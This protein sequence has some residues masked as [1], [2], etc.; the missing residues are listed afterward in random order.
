MAR[1]PQEITRD[2]V[3]YMDAPLREATAML[4]EPV[5]TIVGYYF[6]WVEADG[7]PA[8]PVGV[9]RRPATL[10]LLST[11]SEE[12]AWQRARNAATAMTFMEAATIV[13]DDIQDNDTLRNGRPSVWA[14]F[15]RPAA[16]Q[17]G[18]A[19]LAL[20]FELLARE[21]A[22]IAAEA[23]RWNSFAAREA[24]SGQIRDMREAADPRISL[25][26]SLATREGNS[27]KQIAA[28]P[29]VGALCRGAS[30]AEVEAAYAFGYHA[31][32]ALAVYDAWEGTWGSARG[33]L[34]EGM[35]DLRQ[36]KMLPYVAFALQTQGPARDRLA[37]IYAAAEEP[38]PSQ[39]PH[40]RALIEACGGRS[41]L[42]DQIRQH[43]HDARDALAT[44]LPD[45][46]ARAELAAWLDAL[47][48]EPS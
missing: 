14:A 7:R 23:I 13:H 1:S 33:A 30:P 29:A 24:C 44:A 31:G 4:T 8:T 21:P 26:Q 43:V 5:R 35:A 39:L 6:G 10:V 27:G 9:R 19:M 2:V 12:A 45:P 3:A 22:P 36:R 32:T 15:G 25:Q 37:A 48:G 47:T 17:A 42:V 40:I 41:W 34:E 18:V 38:Q 11:G 28:L 16:L 46:T 20:S